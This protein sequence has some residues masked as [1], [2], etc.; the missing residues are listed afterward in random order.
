MYLRISKNTIF[1]VLCLVLCACQ[2][3]NLLESWPADVPNRQ[4]FIDGYLEKRGKKP[5]ENSKALNNHL[6]WIVK[7]YKGTP[8]YPQ[9]W[10]R[11][12][13]RYLATIKDEEVRQ[14][15]EM[16]LHVLGIKI[17]N[18]WAQA[19]KDRLINNRVILTW[20]NGLRTSAERMEQE[21]YAMEVERD[22]E[23]LLNKEI[24]FK[25]INFERYFPSGSGNDDNFDD[26]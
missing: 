3:T 10:N 6:A 17:A 13:G 7:F 24:S 9:G 18:E 8:F 12:S 21:R 1:I 23:L 26:F 5:E 15:L 22:V 16:R 11:I 19:N 25:E 14:S 2:T 4:V 20:G